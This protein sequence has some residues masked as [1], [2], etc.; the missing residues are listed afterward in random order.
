MEPLADLFGVLDDYKPRQVGLTKLT[1]VPHRKR[2]EL[3]PLC[4]ENIRVCYTRSGVIPRAK[5]RSWREFSLLLLSAMQRDLVSQ[6][7]GWREFAAFSS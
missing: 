1:K 7:D 4:D 6:L 5:N 2:P 3:I